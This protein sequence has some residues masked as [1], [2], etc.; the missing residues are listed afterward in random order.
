MPDDVG[1]RLESSLALVAGCNLVTVRDRAVL[2]VS[3]KY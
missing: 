3:Q 1:H 2:L